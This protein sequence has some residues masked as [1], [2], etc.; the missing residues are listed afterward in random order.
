MT[1]PVPEICLTATPLEPGP[2]VFSA[3]AGAALDFYGVVRG[4]EEAETITGIGYEAHEEMARHQLE[5]LAREV[6]GRFPV[7]QLVV[8]HR[9]GFVPVAEPSLF[10]RVSSGHRGTAFAAAQ[11]F[12]DQ[13]KERIPIWKHPVFETPQRSQPEAAP[14]QAPPPR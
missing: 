2:A 10:L 6:M 9:I 11:W 7:L 3:A 13:L 1:K 5:L 12:I 4:Q 8:H 14:A